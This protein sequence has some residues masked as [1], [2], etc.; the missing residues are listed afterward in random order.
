MKKRVRNVFIGHEN[1]VTSIDF[2]PNSRF[3][4]S[5]SDDKTTRIWYIRDGTSRLLEAGDHASFSTAVR[6]SP[7]GQYI[8]TVNYDE[9]LR[10]WNFR[11]NHLVEKWR[12][13]TKP[14]LAV[15][16]T[17]DGYGLVSGSRD[18]ALKYWDFSQVGLPGSEGRNRGGTVEQKKEVLEFNWHT[19]RLLYVLFSP[20]FI[21]SLFS[22]LTY[23]MILIPFPY[24]P[25]VNGSSPA[26]MT[27]PCVSGTLAMLL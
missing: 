24:H 27:K 22:F 13:H 20:S 19:V 25:M 21:Y 3:L 5:S 18:G 4:V 1:R 14:L 15:T 23:R 12:A 26:Q 8:A 10:I 16:F 9:M 17:P 11:T 7:Y 6:F 2:S